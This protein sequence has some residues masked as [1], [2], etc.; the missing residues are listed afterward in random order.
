MH[1]LNV[2]LLAAAAAC[3]VPRPLGPSAA[4]ALSQLPHRIGWQPRP[5][6]SD[7]ILP[8]M[9]LP[10]PLLRYEETPRAVVPTEQD[11]LSKE[12]D[13][14]NQMDDDEELTPFVEE[15]SRW[16][17]R[18]PYVPL[19]YGQ[20]AVR[21]PAEPAYVPETMTPTP[22]EIR[23]VPPPRE[24]VSP[25]PISAPQ[26][27][28]RNQVS[29]TVAPAKTENEEN[30]KTFALTPL[31]KEYYEPE[32]KTDTQKSDGPHEGGESPAPQAMSL[33]AFQ[34]PRP[35]R[36][37]PNLGRT[38]NLVAEN[39]DR[40]RV[41]VA[42]KDYRIPVSLLPTN[43]RWLRINPTDVPE[44]STQENPD[45]TD[46]PRHIHVLESASDPADSIYGIA[47]IAAVGTALTMAIIGFAFGW[48]TLSKKA[49]A[50]AD[51]DYPA[52]GVTG[53][54]I[55]TSGDRKLAHSAHMYHYQHQKQQIIAM[56]RN[57]CEHRNGS[58]SD[59]ESEEENEEGD[60][61]VYECPGFATTGEMEVKN[62]LFSE[63]PTPATPGKCEIVKPQPKD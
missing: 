11:W 43:L 34:P 62:P 59:P 56:E 35:I 3:A 33:V 13:R 51:V 47:L 24:I 4:P 18:D 28:A 9:L 44:T 32:E 1:T 50:A 42:N 37:N 60:Y 31:D 10:N 39:L 16:M 20:E 45:G 38:K 8:R 46:K 30:K 12:I 2:L 54:N 55:D 22:E 40:L 26:V 17:A 49:K 29:S 57:G 6:R 19:K 61:T 58:V 21:E 25:E 15:F 23:P 41:G 14:I 48:Y 53:P 52:Y 27:E 5:F 63:D 7:Y 36:Q